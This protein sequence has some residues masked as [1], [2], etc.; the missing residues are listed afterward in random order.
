MKLIWLDG[1]RFNVQNVGQERLSFL[2]ANLDME[3]CQIPPRYDGYVWC[4]DQP[5][6][7]IGLYGYRGLISMACSHGE[8]DKL[9]PD[10]G[11]TR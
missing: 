7:G 6:R 8:P 1:E 9:Y 2:S 10:H 11:T 5:W 3:I 4:F